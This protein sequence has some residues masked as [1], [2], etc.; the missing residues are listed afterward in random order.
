MLILHFPVLSPFFFPA[1][2]INMLVHVYM[3]SWILYKQY[4]FF[5]F[6]LFIIKFLFSR[7]GVSV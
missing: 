7:Q 1:D 3:V 2:F 6:V 4:F 5:L